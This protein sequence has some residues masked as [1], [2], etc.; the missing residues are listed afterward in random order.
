VWYNMESKTYTISV[1]NTEV[2]LLH[3][4]CLSFAVTLFHES[5]KYFVFATC[6]LTSKRL[7]RK[8]A[9]NSIIFII[10]CCIDICGAL[11]STGVAIYY[12]QSQPTPLFSSCNNGR[13]FILCKKHTIISI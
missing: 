7:L 6:F 3:Q 2:T 12:F 5:A 8:L 13:I 11:L 10:Y 1:N 9:G 4:D